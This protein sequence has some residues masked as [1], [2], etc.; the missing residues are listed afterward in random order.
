[1]IEG[2]VSRLRHQAEHCRRLALD[3]NDDKT[4][5]ALLGMALEYERKADRFERIQHRVGQAAGPGYH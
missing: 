5:R 3:V 1:M 2:N 4:I